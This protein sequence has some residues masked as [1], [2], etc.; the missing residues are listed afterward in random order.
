MDP[1]G[2]E[3]LFCSLRLTACRRRDRPRAAGGTGAAPPLP[4]VALGRPPPLSEPQF[5]TWQVCRVGRGGEGH[6]AR[7]CVLR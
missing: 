4:P 1:L 7:C 5:L 6:R 2:L 3:S